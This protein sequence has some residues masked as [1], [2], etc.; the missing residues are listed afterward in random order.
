MFYLIG[1]T[2]EVQSI[3]LAVK[4]QPTTEAFRLCLEQT[5]QE[6]Q[7]AFVAEEYQ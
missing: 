7:P 3:P 5:I 6:Y 2:H 4:K 1:V